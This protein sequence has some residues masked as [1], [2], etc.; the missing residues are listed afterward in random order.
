MMA[1]RVGNVIVA[2]HDDILQ[3]LPDKRIC[4]SAHD[5]CTASNIHLGW[6]SATSE[7]VH[8][9]LSTRMAIASKSKAELRLSPWVKRLATLSATQ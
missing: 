4:I 5:W 9:P 3:H 7:I 2:E 6:P 1:M 8:S